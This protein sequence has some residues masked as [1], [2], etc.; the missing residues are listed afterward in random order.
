MSCCTEL[1]NGRTG[2]KREERESEMD[3]YQTAICTYECCIA[4][5]LSRK[6]RSMFGVRTSCK[7][8]WFGFVFLS[9][10][11]STVAAVQGQGSIPSGVDDRNS[12]G[13]QT[14]ELKQEE[15]DGS[16]YCVSR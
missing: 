7:G 4:V 16:L 6:K 12:R 2:H 10:A 8:A 15:L 1:E 14:G 13:T 5:P 11:G 3:T 9:F